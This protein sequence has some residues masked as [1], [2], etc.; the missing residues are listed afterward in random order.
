MSVYMVFNSE[1][2]SIYYPNNQPHNFIVN[3]ATPLQLNGFWMVALVDFKTEGSTF[4]HTHCYLYSDICGDSIVDGVM[5]PLLRRFWCE[6]STDD[7]A[8]VFN[9]RQYKPVMKTVINSI[10]F[11]LKDADGAFLSFLTKPV[12]ITLHLK[13]HP[14]YI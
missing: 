13:A 9:D 2:H 3:L 11:Y 14:F 6:N 8:L 12:T 1:K 5:Q 7:Y 4:L 10:R